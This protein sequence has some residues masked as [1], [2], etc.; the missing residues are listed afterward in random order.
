MTNSIR[1]LLVFTL[2]AGCGL[3]Q[4]QVQLEKERAMGS[5]W[6]KLTLTESRVADDAFVNAQV[7][8][9]GQELAQRCPSGRQIE[10]HVLVD[11]N[12]N[13]YALPG[14]FLFVNTGLIR[15]TD[16]ESELAA[17]LAHLISR[18][19]AGP[20]AT[21]GVLGDARIPLIYM[22]GGRGHTYRPDSSELL[23]PLGFHRFNRPRVTAADEEGAR[24]LA[25]AMYDPEG[26]LRSLEKVRQSEAGRSEAA[27]RNSGHP[28]A[29]ERIE[30]VQAALD[31]VP[32]Q[33][34]RVVTTNRFVE[35]KNRVELLY[36]PVRQRAKASGEPDGPPRLRR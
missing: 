28:P 33:T 10:V 36:P 21:H 35:L 31:T 12:P 30:R 19:K 32:P 34:D 4:D 2:I 9:I 11:S 15:R 29:A 23:V 5:Q 3:C 13:A 8:R 27:M 17:V 24:C 22:G 26:V 16:T 6:A 1:T 25:S 7:D 20:A 14:G 18:V